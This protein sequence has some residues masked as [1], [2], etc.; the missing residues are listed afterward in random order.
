MPTVA[1]VSLKSDARVAMQKLMDQGAGAIRY[2]MGVIAFV[3]TFGIIYNAARIAYAERAR[4]LASLR[5][6]GFTT[7][8]T[9][10]VL[11]GELAVITLIAIPIG[12]VLGYYLSFGIAA[13]FSTDLYQIPAVFDPEATALR[14]CSCWALRSFPAGW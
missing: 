8:E 2:V 6:I 7:G 11:L 12:A 10:F 9:G 3:I 1:G 13:G 5:V 4:D 14:C